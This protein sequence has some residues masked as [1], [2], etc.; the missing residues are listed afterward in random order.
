MIEILEDYEPLIGSE[1]VERIREAAK[2]LKGLR[3]SNFNSTYYRRRRGRD[4][5][6]AYPRHGRFF[7][8]AGTFSIHSAHA[9]KSAFSF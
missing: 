8:K 2:K 5:F 6:F 3:V 7:L 9:R 1:K 4:A